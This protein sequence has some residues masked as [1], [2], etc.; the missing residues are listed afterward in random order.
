MKLLKNKF[1]S[2]L[3]ALTFIVSAFLLPAN[4]QAAEVRQALIHQNRSYQYLQPIG[5]VIHDTDNPG[6]T[7]QNNHDYFDRNYVAASAHYFMDWKIGIQCVPE[8][9]VAWHAG[10]TAN[11]RYLSIEMC[12]PGKHNPE[13]FNQVYQNTV[14]LAA[15]I[16][17]RYGWSSANV[18]SHYWCSMIFKETDH[19]DPIAYLGEYGKTWTDLLAD[20]QK[21]INGQTVTQTSNQVPASSTTATLQAN[22]NKLKIA[23]L[24]VDNSYG[25]LTKA[26]VRKFQSIMGL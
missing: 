3:I 22:L 7:A 2:F 17:K 11:H 14:E 13:Q 15:Q 4:V 10:Y 25:P 19:T 16:C 5:L 23:N 12:M 8:S 24:A 21:A 26:A 9:E 18:Y 20:I 6:S 1:I